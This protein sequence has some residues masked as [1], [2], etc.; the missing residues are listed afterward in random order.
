MLSASKSLVPNKHGASHARRLRHAIFNLAVSGV[1]ANLGVSVGSS[2]ICRHIS[3]SEQI[4][5]PHTATMWFGADNL[6]V[7]GCE[8]QMHVYAD[9]KVSISFRSWGRMPVNNTGMTHANRSA[10]LKSQGPSPIILLQYLSSTMAT[11]S[12][13]KIA[14]LHF[15][16]P[17]EA[18]YIGRGTTN[19][20]VFSPCLQRASYWTTVQETKHLV[21]NCTSGQWWSEEC[22]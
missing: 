3:P 9:N 1:G 13:Q 4:R 17:Q 2:Q 8:W 19:S 22:I 10:P 21:R 18:H 7:A 12:M 20:I 11:H 16:F 14:V 15:H 6:A 5:R